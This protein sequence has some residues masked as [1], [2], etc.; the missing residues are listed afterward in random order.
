MEMVKS[1]MV[2]RGK[3]VSGGAE[4]MEHRRFLH[5][6]NTVDDTIM[7]DTGIIQS[8]KPIAPTIPRVN[9]M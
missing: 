9:P 3:V 1:S 6:E 4:E 5:R 2:T 7:M 8:F